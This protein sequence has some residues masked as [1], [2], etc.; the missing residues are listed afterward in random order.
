MSQWLADLDPGSNQ[1]H[2]K[3][4]AALRQIG[5]NSFPVLLKMLRAKDSAW[6]TGLMNFE[7]KH[8]RVRFHV[9]PASAVRQRAVQGYLALG[10]EARSTVPGL[11]E[12]LKTEPSPQVRS[13]VAG[14]LGSIGPEARAAIPELVKAAHDKNSELQQSAMVA[15]SNIRAFDSPNTRF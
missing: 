5:T 3:A 10:S 6:K 13:T 7:N 8:P 15:L 9:A 1:S 4:Q 11:I 14:A 2:E 12:I